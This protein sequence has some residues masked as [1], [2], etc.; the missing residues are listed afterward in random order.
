MP[1]GA[2]EGGIAVV[3][4]VIR[5]ST[6]IITALA[7]ES[8]GV[9]PTDAVDKARSRAAMLGGKTLLGGERNCVRIEGF[10]LGNS[11]RE[12]TRAR[13]AGRPIVFTTTNGTAALAACQDAAVVLIGSL[14]NRSAVA[15]AARHAAARGA[16]QADH[17]TVHLV[18]AGVE[19]QVAD[20]DILGAG[21][22]AD[23]AQTLFPNDVL[24]HAA[25]EARAQFLAAAGQETGATA[26]AQLTASLASTAGGRRIVALGMQDD[27]LVVADLDAH[28]TVPIFDPTSGILTPIP[29]PKAP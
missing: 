2:V 16:A 4:D 21:A 27:L 1:E 9:I 15:A 23:A 5:A 29:A 18:C 6:T 22:I 3:I 19:G 17:A 20:E 10:Q 11:P 8:A 26:I 12:Y 7:N 25:R 28:D 14:V 13:V 24:D